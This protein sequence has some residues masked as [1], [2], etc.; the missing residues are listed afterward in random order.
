M[1]VVFSLGVS[2]FRGIRFLVVGFVGIDGLSWVDCFLGFIWDLEESFF[3]VGGEVGV[4]RLV[5]LSYFFDSVDGE[6]DGWGGE[7][8]GGRSI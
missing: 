4:L 6:R 3:L 1:F 5:I 2:L 7:R 8:G